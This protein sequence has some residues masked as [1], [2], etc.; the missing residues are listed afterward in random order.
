MAKETFFNRTKLDVAQ[1]A[2]ALD[3]RITL[4][5]PSFPNKDWQYLSNITN[6][7]HHVFYMTKSVRN[8]SYS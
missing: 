7:Y 1:R 8:I 3:Q 4:Y 6:K 2:I 5:D